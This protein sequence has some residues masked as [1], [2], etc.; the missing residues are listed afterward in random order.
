MKQNRPFHIIT[1][2]AAALLMFTACQGWPA[3]DTSRR[4]AALA[5]MRLSRLSQ[6]NKLVFVEYTLKELCGSRDETVWR[7]LGDK[8]VLYSI[9]AHVTA[10]IDMRKMPSD[11]LTLLDDSTVMLTLPH[12]EVL[13]IDIPNSEVRNVYERIT[14]ISSDLTAA[15]RGQVLARGEKNVSSTIRQLDILQQAEDKATQFFRAMLAQ[16]GFKPSRCKIVY[17][18]YRP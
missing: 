7:I 10:G 15:E 17:E 12:V 5:E 3:D 1:A 16:A 18:P 14:G 4:K 13:G 8:E 6:E 11:A 9:T 2:I